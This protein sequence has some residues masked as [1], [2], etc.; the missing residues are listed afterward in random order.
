MLVAPHVVEVCIFPLLYITV[1]VE[2]AKIMLL[3]LI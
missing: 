3:V 2:L 1:L